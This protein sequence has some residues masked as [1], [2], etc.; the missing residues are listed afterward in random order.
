[1]VCAV[2]RAAESDAPSTPDCE[3]VP[4]MRTRSMKLG[5]MGASLGLILLASSVAPAYAGTSVRSEL[6]SP[7]SCSAFQGLTATGPSF[8]ATG[9]TLRAGETIRASVNPARSEDTIFLN[10]SAEGQ[11]INIIVGEGP[12]SGFEFSPGPGVYSLQWTYV[13]ATTVPSGLTWYFTAD[14]SS[15]SVTPTP[16]PTPTAT[17]KPGKGGG[18][19]GGN[20]GGKGSGKG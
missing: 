7:T 12:T 17:T 9:I 10:G 8:A 6:S 20:G 14:C 15:T 3:K 5:A 11:G 19:G 16:A 1:M 4:T 2:H 18:K 13:T